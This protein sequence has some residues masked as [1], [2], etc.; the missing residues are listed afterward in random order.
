MR[1]WMPSCREARGRARAARGR[2]AG[3][4]VFLIAVAL[5]GHSTWGQEPPPLSPAAGETMP[6][7]R[8]GGP[9]A[10]RSLPILPFWRAET[11]YQAGRTEEALSRFLDLA[12]NYSDDERKGF[13]WMRVGEILL[14]K[15]ELDAALSSADKAVLLS[16]ASFLALS[17]MDLKFRI[18]RR[19]NWRSEARQLAAYLLE[20]H[21]VNADPPKLLTVMA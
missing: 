17:A 21:Y 1:A 18:Y 12:Y 11:E 9:A 13:V 20:K 3:A 4:L 10:G 14:A 8:P 5:G 2:F 15:G 7:A 6:V 16:R 19:M